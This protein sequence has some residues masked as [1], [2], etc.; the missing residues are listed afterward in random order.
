MIYLDFNATTPLRPEALAAVEGALREAFG[1]PSSPHA[2]GVTARYA[3]EKS[4]R[5]LARAIGAGTTPSEVVFTSGGTEANALA[6][7]GAELCAPGPIVTTAAEH[8]AVLEAMT[9]LAEASGRTLRVVPVDAQGR[10]APESLREALTPD[11]ALASIMLA[12]NEVGTLN[13]LP[14]LAAVVRAAAPRAVLHCDAVQALGKVPVDVCALGADLVSFCAHKLGGPKGIGALW[15]RPGVPLRGVLRGGPQEAGRRAGT[16]NT[17]AIV[18]F[19]RAAEVAVAGMAAEAPRQEA[20][21]ERLW[22]VLRAGG[23]PCRRLSPREGCLPNTLAVAF[24]GESAR[25]LL[26]ELDAA[27]ICASTGSACT[28]AGTEPSHV[29]RALGLDP[30]EARGVLRFSLGWTTTE[31]QVDAVGAWWRGR[32]ATP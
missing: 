3:V 9:Q 16:E 30:T 10:V 2:A 25:G 27:G 15:V 24:A 19:A 14:E 20:L 12:N 6:L 26:D 5:T 32:R 4:R 8:K 31:A 7:L 23:A 28:A 22:H 29:L 13:P 11:V 18:G 17:P 21:R 1:N